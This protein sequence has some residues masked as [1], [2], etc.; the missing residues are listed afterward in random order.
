MIVLFQACCP[1]RHMKHINLI[2]KPTTSSHQSHLSLTEKILGHNN[3]CMYQHVK[4]LNR[5]NYFNAKYH[6]QPRMMYFTHH[7][8]THRP[9][10]WPP[11]R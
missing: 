5:L 2:E 8:M 3:I 4:K 1:A 11:E 7:L 9:V 10:G 6:A